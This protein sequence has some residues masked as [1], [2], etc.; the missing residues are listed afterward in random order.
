M[1]QQD[2]LTG[3]IAM[4]HPEKIPTVLEIVKKNA[5]AR[6]ISTISLENN[7]DLKTVQSRAR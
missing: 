7:L 5:L 1:A 3:S 2:V 6:S 4:V